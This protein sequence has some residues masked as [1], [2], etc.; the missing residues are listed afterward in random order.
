[1]H[2]KEN[3][4]IPELLAPAGSYEGLKAVIAAGADAVYI[5]GSRFGAR[6]YADNP[7]EDQLIDA[8]EY[9]HLRGVK[10]YLT[11]NTLLKED[12]LE[13]LPDWIRPYVERGVDAVLVQDFG[14]L[15]IL[16]KHFPQLVLHASTQMCVSGPEGAKLLSSCGISRIVPARELSIRELKTLKEE[17]GLEVECFIHGALCY[18]YSGLCLFS[19]IAGG[20][21]GNRG[22]CAQPCR[23]L[24]LVD[25]RHF[26]GRT[27]IMEE[28]EARHFLSPKD[29]NTLS[30]L[31]ELI[32]A[33]I[34]SFKIEGRMKQPEYAAGVVSVY[35]KHL[36][37]LVSGKMREHQQSLK[38]D[39]QVLYDL[40]NRNGFT[41][42]Y[43]TRHN[44]KSM[45]APVKHV[46]TDEET[47][48]RHSLYDKM[49]EQY[50]SVPDQIPLEA[51]FTV[52][53]GE[54]IQATL[55]RGHLHV[56][57]SGPK[58][59]A[60]LK[61]PL[62]K[63]QIT[64]Q[65]MKTGGSDF[66]FRK[67]ELHT[68]GQSFLPLSRLNEFRRNS[69][70]EMRT[71]ILR[72]YT[73]NAEKNRSVYVFENDSLTEQP[74]STPELHAVVSNMNQLKAVL[75]SDVSL[76]YAEAELLL[77]RGAE[78]I[79]LIKKAGKRA[80]AAMPRMDRADSYSS[81][82]RGM[83]RS[84][85]EYGCEVFLAR[86]FESAAFLVN[87]GLEQHLRADAGIYSWN[88][89]SIRFLR[90]H[91]ICFITAPYELNRKELFG[92]YNYTSEMVVYGKL[93]L[94]V[95]AN[96]LTETMGGCTRANENHTLTDRTGRRFNVRC[97]CDFCYNV[98][99][100]YVPLN[101]LPEAQTLQ[102]MGFEAWRV[103]F[104]DESAEEC[105]SVL[106]AAVRAINGE[107][108]SSFG[109]A[110]KGHFLRGVE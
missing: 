29:L 37:L 10:V 58:A 33:G 97:H 15:R 95:S 101:L 3:G 22:R 98:I 63:E 91:G 41:D 52:L 21:S 107:T 39:N 93:P 76:I 11:V 18:C 35:R 104:T 85:M 6:A 27:S 81:K 16:R 62:N 50:M 94:M 2:I 43:F 80:G 109:D 59:E 86:C 28:P 55:Q 99:S 51:E 44:G 12:E 83:I 108:V 68:D 84:L 5:G 88:S 45:M 74:H 49:H 46:L 106:D 1:M 31:P 102:R 34:D 47:R 100:N 61:K 66:Y 89:E 23:L 92:R 82:F 75:R 57:T 40:Y 71:A 14:V 20:R 77:K 8:I 30:L 38:E 64:E 69:L 96:C 48:K 90:E 17:S 25:D 13:S 103:D 36:D 4:K 70:E 65:L 54:A 42:G 32:E 110:T 79:S 19:S 60:A 73:E 7:E 67:M 56:G 87:E 24:G 53:K 78:V 72:D 26:D 105:G 9:A